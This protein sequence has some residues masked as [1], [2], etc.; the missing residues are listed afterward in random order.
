MTGGGPKIEK[1][2]KQRRDIKN[3]PTIYLDKEPEEEIPEPKYRLN[4][5]SKLTN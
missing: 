4:K 3:Y 2:P 1:I 5:I